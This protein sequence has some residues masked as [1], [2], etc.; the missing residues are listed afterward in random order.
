MPSSCGW[1][2]GP[3]K[4]LFDRF[5]NG[6]LGS[7]SKQC[8]FHCRSLVR[9]ELDFGFEP[10]YDSAGRSYLFVHFLNEFP[11]QVFS[12]TNTI[13]LRDRAFMIKTTFGQIHI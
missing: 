2:L 1:R 6:K 11:F 5:R 4:L 3:L 7:E 12:V 10:I 8:M 13:I 9:H